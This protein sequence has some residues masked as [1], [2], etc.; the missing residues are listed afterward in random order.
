M[1][2]PVI[3]PTPLSAGVKN[4]YILD[5]FFVTSV[6]RDVMS[7]CFSFA[8]RRSESETEIFNS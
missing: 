5:K 7:C 8:K 2:F 6:L 3:V 4:N 1:D